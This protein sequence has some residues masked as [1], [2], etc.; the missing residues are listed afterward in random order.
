M[1]WLKPDFDR[2]RSTS[3][4]TPTSPP[5]RV[6]CS[7]PGSWSGR[8]S[9]TRAWSTATRC[10][11]TTDRKRRRDAAICVVHRRRAAGRG[12]V[13][14]Q[15]ANPT[16]ALLLPYVS[17][18]VYTVNAGGNTDGIYLRGD[19][20]F[21]AAT[22]PAP[23]LQHPDAGV[24]P[25][26]AGAGPGAGADR[27]RRRLT[28][29]DLGARPSPAC[30]RAPASGLPDP[31]TGGG[32]G[33]RFSPFRGR[34]RSDKIQI[35]PVIRRLYPIAAAG[36]ALLVPTLGGGGDP[37][38]ASASA[39]A[40]A[41]G[42][43]SS[44][45]LDAAGGACW[46]PLPEPPEASHDLAAR[47]PTHPRE[48]LLSF[49]DGPDLRGTPLILDELDR[50][51]IKAVFFV[52]GWRLAGDRPEDVARRDLV[53][54]IARH[55]HLVANHTMTHKNLCQN[56]R[57]Q[58]VE[59]DDAAEIVEQVT[60]VPPLLFR[61]PYGAQLSQPAGRAGGAR[62]AQRPLEP[63]SAGLEERRRG[64]HLPLHHAEA[65]E[66]GGARDPAAAR[67]APGVGE[68]AAG[69]ARLDRAREPPREP[70][71]RARPSR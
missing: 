50:R 32:R 41:R 68:R 61:S 14:Q 45:M 48:L 71:V 3:A 35:S 59:I 37:S 29:G 31:R 57:E 66:A 62:S 63:G 30:R 4:T 43:T 27:L 12:T 65:V 49:D 42:A 34:T 17:A 67:H 20:P 5:A 13:I 39:L 19:L 58:A 18:V 26:D 47:P 70:R 56:P 64:G 33:S 7:R 8:R 51:G 15:R 54:K 60:G 2:S 21:P 1:F 24:G 44:A 22:P 46:V 55:G 28:E 36:V 52:T 23:P 11:S 25:T 53:R 9:R 16:F 69:G 40:A 38:L 10:F 6:R